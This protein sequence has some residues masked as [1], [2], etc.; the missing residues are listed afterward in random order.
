MLGLGLPLVL[1]VLVL[2]LYWQSIIE[3]VLLGFF[4]MTVSQDKMLCTL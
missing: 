3:E 1:L 2:A 4:P